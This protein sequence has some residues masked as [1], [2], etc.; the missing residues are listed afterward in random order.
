MLGATERQSSQRTDSAVWPPSRRSAGL[1][2]ATRLERWLSNGIERRLLRLLEQGALLVEEPNVAVD[3]PSQS[4]RLRK[5]QLSAAISEVLATGG[6]M[7]LSGPQC[8]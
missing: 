5:G 6:E 1:D 4:I 7:R 2:L 3:V 8:R